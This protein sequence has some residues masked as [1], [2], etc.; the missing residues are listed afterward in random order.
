MRCICH[1][2]AQVKQHIQTLNINAFY[3][4]RKS[5][6]NDGLLNVEIVANRQ[7]LKTLDTES[8]LHTILINQ[9]TNSYSNSKIVACAKNLAKLAREGDP[10]KLMESIMITPSAAQ[11][12]AKP[13]CAG[14]LCLKI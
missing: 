14:W 11:Q 2:P 1:R 9:L 12:V 4:H 5:N 7:G 8:W 3:K 6:K 10:I 13:S